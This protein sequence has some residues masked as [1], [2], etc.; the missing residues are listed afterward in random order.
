MEIFLD[1]IKYYFLNNYSGQYR[2]D[3]LFLFKNIFLLHFFIFYI[4]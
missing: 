3:N 2:K 1:D 4:I